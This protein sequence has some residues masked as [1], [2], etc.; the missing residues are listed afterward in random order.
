MKDSL[1]QVETRIYYD[2]GRLLYLYL[3]MLFHT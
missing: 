1:S 3:M 2:V